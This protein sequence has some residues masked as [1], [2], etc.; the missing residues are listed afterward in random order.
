LKVL[1][2]LPTWLGDAVMTSPAIENIISFDSSAKIT[3]IGSRSAIDLFS[4]HPNA[5]NFFVVEK[6][7][8]KLYKLSKSLG[9][10]DIFI[11]FRGSLTASLFSFLVKAKKKYQY[12]KNA[13]S[14]GHQV[15]KYNHFISNIFDFSFVPKK[16][17]IHFKAKANDNNQPCLG[18]N[19]GASYG[20]AKRWTSEGFFQISR[21]LSRKYKIIIF[22][23]IDDIESSLEIEK[24]LKLHSI[25]NYE[26]LTGKTSIHELVNK[27][28]A[29]DLFIT[30]DSGPMHIA[31]AFEIP[32]VSIFGPTKHHETSQ[33]S[34]QKNIIV[35]KSLSCQ[36]CMKRT[37]PLGHHNCMKLISK[38]DVIQA[39]KSLENGLNI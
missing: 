3:F 34:N 12:R 14:S 35:K 25:S 27:I 6:K 7:L 8:L 29:L 19:P 15:E 31:A 39:V 22:G 5:A 36:P 16:L 4:F 2:E 1:I 18:I 23:G 30:G 20:A 13:Y 21:D 26:N 28:S 24:K 9:S 32:T 33:W 11:T 17:K 38:E 37:C 10:F